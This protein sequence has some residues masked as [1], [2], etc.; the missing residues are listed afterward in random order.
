MNDPDALTEAKIKELEQQF[1]EDRDMPGVELIGKTGDMWLVHPYAA[2]SKG[3]GPSQPM[4]PI[5]YAEFP[6]LL[7]PEWKLKFTRSG[8]QK[9]SMVESH[10]RLALGLATL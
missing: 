6:V 3:V 5:S 10:V 8:H 4:P 9:H 2:M 1:N 7:N